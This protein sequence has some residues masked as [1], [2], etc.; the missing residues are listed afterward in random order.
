MER[1]DAIEKF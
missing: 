1:M